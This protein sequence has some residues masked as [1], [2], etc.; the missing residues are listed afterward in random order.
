MEKTFVSRHPIYESHVNLLAY[1]LRSQNRVA[2]G[3]GAI[4]SETTKADLRT[5]S[6]VGLDH[7]AGNH[8][9]FVN[10]SREAVLGGHCDALSKQRVVLEVLRDIVFDESLRDGLES[11]AARGYK[12]AIPDPLVGDD[13]VNLASIA[14]IVRVDVRE[15]GEAELSKHMEVL[16][17]LSVKLLAEQI[18]TYEKFELCRRFNFDY[19][20]GFFFC[21]PK[22][23]HQQFEHSD[24]D[25]DVPVNRLAAGRVLAAL[26][27][28]ELSINNL[29]EVISS[30]L[31]LSYKLCRYTNSAYIGLNR[32]VDFVTLSWPTFDRLIWPT[33]DN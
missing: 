16:S 29:E 14:D 31:S 19:F 6:D 32:Q 11:L 33:P 9:A 20:Q 22:V 25:H 13:A 3:N 1:E 15:M 30:D 8:L 17:K 10:V 4:D 7:I 18:D 23:E 24:S 12:I 5:F 21:T 27:D 2:N 26:Q 28:P